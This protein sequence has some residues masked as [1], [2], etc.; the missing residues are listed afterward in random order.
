MTASARRTPSSGM[1]HPRPAAGGQ[2]RHTSTCAT[3]QILAHRRPPG[4]SA[5]PAP[6]PTR[7]QTASGAAPLQSQRADERR[8][9]QRPTRA[10]AASPTSPPRRPAP[11]DRARRAPPLRR[12]N[13][14]RRG[15]PDADGGREPRTAASISYSK[16]SANADQREVRPQPVA[17]SL[18]GDGPPKN[19][20]RPRR[21]TSLRR[22]CR[23]RP[24]PRCAHLGAPARTPTPAASAARYSNSFG[25]SPGALATTH[26]RRT[27]GRL[28]AARCGVSPRGTQASNKWAMPLEPR[29]GRA[30][31]PPPR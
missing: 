29:V 8:R 27:P 5:R 16:H 22:R 17:T 4:Q 28:S 3:Q 30:D 12:N 31:D 1:Q 21:V 19:A 18:A 15:G 23:H 11:R 26:P 14:P 24:G 9:E 10:G 13:V 20:P 7:S 2:R 25:W 6:G